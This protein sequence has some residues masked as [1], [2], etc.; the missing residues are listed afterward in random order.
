MAIDTLHYYSNRLLWL[1]SQYT[2]TVFMKDGDHPHITRG[3]KLLP[4]RD[5]GDDT[6]I[7]RKLS[8]A[9]PPKSPDLNPSNF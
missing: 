9:W 3:V 5:F 6:I 1:F 2:T 4:Y 7:N 8:T